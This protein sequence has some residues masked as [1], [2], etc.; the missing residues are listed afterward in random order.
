[1]SLRP[2]SLR[3]DKQ[4]KKAL[5]WHEEFW[6]DFDKHKSYHSGIDSMSS[7]SCWIIS[8]FFLVIRDSSKS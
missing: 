8:R 2:Y 1:M 3:K 6:P 4:L 5:S 7:S